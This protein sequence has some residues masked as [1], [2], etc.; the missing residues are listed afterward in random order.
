MHLSLLVGALKLT[1]RKS[2]GQ[3]NESPDWRSDGDA[4]VTSHISCIERAG[5]VHTDGGASGYRGWVG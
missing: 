3:I 1:G 2:L 5:R 4:F